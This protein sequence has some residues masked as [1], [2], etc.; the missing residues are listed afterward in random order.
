MTLGHRP[1]VTIGAGE[2]KFP[3]RGGDPGRPEATA[4]VWPLRNP[5]YSSTVPPRLNQCS[6][7]YH[8]RWPQ[9]IWALL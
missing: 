2:V 9:G 5:Q 6:G 8:Y 4:L 3:Q 1:V 7:L